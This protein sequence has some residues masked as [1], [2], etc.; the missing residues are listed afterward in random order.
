LQRLIDLLTDESRVKPNPKRTTTQQEYSK[1]TS[2]SDDGKT[3]NDHVCANL[4]E[5]K[6]EDV[7]SNVLSQM[8]IP[9]QDPDS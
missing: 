7:I 5:K 4:D 6:R 8:V 3:G 9:V 1:A 2:H